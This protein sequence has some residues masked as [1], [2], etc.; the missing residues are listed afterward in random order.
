MTRAGGIIIAGLVA[1]LA[2]CTGLPETAQGVTRAVVY[3]G[4]EYMVHFSV[5]EVT[6]TLPAPATRHGAL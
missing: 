3:E 5:S 4:N 2:G 1:A 6:E